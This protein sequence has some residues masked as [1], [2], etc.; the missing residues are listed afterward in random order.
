ML[1]YVSTVRLVK[2]SISSGPLV[3]KHSQENEVWATLHSVEID[4]LL[5]EW[6]CKFCRI[7]GSYSSPAVKDTVLI[8]SH[9]QF[10]KF[11]VLSD[12]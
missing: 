1:F 11:L 8:D 10:A 6:S 4:L 9:D 3:L 7:R 5:P 2:E 12:F